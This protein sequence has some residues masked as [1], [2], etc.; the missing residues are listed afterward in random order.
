VKLAAGKGDTTTNGTNFAAGAG[1]AI[2]KQ[3]GEIMKFA[4]KKYKT[5]SH[6]FYSVER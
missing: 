5:H 3:T 4:L 1:C 6:H 2:R